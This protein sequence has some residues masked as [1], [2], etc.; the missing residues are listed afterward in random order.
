M[1]FLEEALLVASAQGALLCAVLLSVPSGNRRANNLLVLYVG[2]ESLHLL[3]LYLVH[4]A[5][6]TVPPPH[7]R[8][9]F[10]LRYLDGPVLYFYVKALT[11]PEFRPRWRDLAHTAVL[12]VWLLW[13]GYL[14]I[15]PGWLQLTTRELKALPSTVIGATFQSVILVVYASL[16][17]ARVL[18]HRNRVQ[19]ALSAVDQLDLRWLQWLL[20]AIVAISI[21]HI[22][23]DGLRLAGGMSADA[24]AVTNLLVTALLI[25][26]ISIGGL[27]QPQIF[28]DRV[29][30]ALE[31]VNSRDDALSTGESE[32]DAKYRKS[33]LDD[34][35]RRELWL[36][37]QALLEREKPYLEPSLDLP[38]LARMLNLKPQELSETIN[39]EYGGS[40]YDLVNSHRVEAAKSLLAGPGAQQ[41]KMLDIALS[42]GFVSQSTFYNR[43]KKVTGLTPAGF[44]DRELSSGA[45]S[46]DSAAA[47]TSPDGVTLAR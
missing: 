40:F 33:G 13:F 8:L 3:Y 14:A 9:A 10:G 28:S 24:K 5:S 12:L 42:V 4:P 41:R 21:V 20:A 38:G 18:H 27:R 47:K 31:G 11:N 2:L 17:L 32:C 35:R 7:L 37:V 26:L 39:R 46:D 6:Q 43:F 34:N 22:L 30:A 15:Q 25:Y 45:M 36:R 44:R 1:D 16:A 19:Q 29:R 23:F